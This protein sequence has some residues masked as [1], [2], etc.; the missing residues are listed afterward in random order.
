MADAKSSAA[1]QHKRRWL[2]VLGIVLGVLIVLLVLAYFTVTSSAFVKGVIL[3]RVGKAMNAD[4]TAGEAGVSPFSQIILKNLKVQ[5]TGTEPLLTAN[6]VRLKY[7]LFDILGG[8]IAVDEVTLDTPT[9]NVIANADGTS[10]LDPLTKSSAPKEA[11][12]NAVN[13]ASP[14]PSK[15]LRI[16][17]K[18]LAVT[19]A[20]IRQTQLF[21]DGSR[22]ETDLLNVNVTLN[23][24]K[25]GATG[26][27]Q[28]SAIASLANQ[29]PSP[30][31]LQTRIDG[32]FDFTPDANFKSVTVK[33]G[34]KFDVAQAAGT[35]K[36]FADF[37]GELDCD[38]T[39]SNIGQVALKFHKSGQQLGQLL[40]SGPFDMAKSEG[41]LNVQILSLDRRVLDFFGASSGVDFGGTTINSTN[42]I[43]LT[44][45]GA[46]I[47][48]SGNVTIANLQLIRANQ[49]TPTLDAEMNYDV[50]IDNGSKTAILR[51]V[52]LSATQNGKPLARAALSQPM[53]LSWSGAAQNVGDSTLDLNVTGMNLADWKPFLGENVGGGTFSLESKLLA[54]AGGKQI[55]FSLNSRIANLNASAGNSK[56]EQA[57]L[58]FTA[59]GS[60]AEFKQFKLD[61]F[62]AQ[63]SRQ[64]KPALTISGSGTSEPSAQTADLNIQLQAGLPELTQLLPQPGAN[65][66][67]GTIDATA[68]I[69]Q[70]GAHQTVSGKL[71]VASLTG[72]FGNDSFQNYSVAANFDVAKNEEQLQSAHAAGN[73]A[74]NA[75]PGGNF[76]VSANYDD[77]KNLNVTAKLDGINESG[78]RPFLESALGDKK[79][80]SI[81]LNGN[82]SAQIDA[83]NN[84][85]AKADLQLANLVV[86]DPA[87]KIPATPLAAGFQLDISEKD[88]VADLNQVKI[89]LTPTDKAKNE[90]Q[91]SGTVD[92]TKTN[93][94]IGSLK[95]A[96]DSLDVTR[97]YDLF[98]AN[99][100][101]APA[102]ANAQAQQPAAATAENANQEPDAMKLPFGLF[103]VDAKIGKFYL[104]EVSVSDL[105]ASAKI[106]GSHVTLD[107]C[108]FTMNGSPVN[109]SIDL[110]LG[111]P[112]YEYG[113]V[114]NAKGI[115][116]APLANSFSTDYA[117]RAKG[118]FFA[119]I[120]IK[121]AGV[122]GKNLKKT[123]VGN[124]DIIVTNAIIEIASQK[125]NTGKPASTR[126]ERY[127]TGPAMQLL[128]GI[129]FVLSDTLGLQELQTSPLT[130]ID[131][132]LKMGSGTITATKVFAGSSALQV[133]TEGTI[134]I[135]NVLTNSTINDWPVHL[136]IGRSSANKL[137]W[138]TT[139]NQMFVTLPDFVT[140]NQT[141]G[142]TGY[143]I[144]K[145]A[146]AEILGRTGLG[147]ANKLTGSKGATN[148][149]QE[150]QNLI[151]SK[152][153]NSLFNLLKN[154]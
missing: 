115:P 4:I 43:E 46:A 72:K 41:R 119:D 11:A 34:A 54:H 19:N 10:N 29:S 135:A 78:L 59:S 55:E 133:Q 37:G 105:T 73:L 120:N 67:S 62:R 6:E 148:T 151:N 100:S 35:M 45:A 32:S 134:T 129:I 50:T 31:S 109:M 40:V 79:L 17:V 104:R 13:A 103:T 114:F 144:N 26:K 125:S 30:G 57:Q 118:D 33:G 89:T 12:T 88:K 149:V 126:V 110:N 139:A 9:I 127:F 128:D 51:A 22:N 2:R 90:V 98:T 106:D 130:E 70:K 136:A 52:N 122:T 152:A 23:D 56:I 61:D 101:P 93:A 112:G 137:G 87:G 111:V 138:P 97:Y 99:K 141:I 47:S 140:L 131:T 63:L 77:K 83:K 145:V 75:K 21:K 42:T 36:D 113:I 80:A 71:T 65:F 16:D 7:H 66:S 116:I 48:A 74:G 96:A 24:L 69:S 3:P 49:S 132:H 153:A 85:N 117:G 92:M 108:Q 121:G 64:N 8:N 143:K 39:P 25:N 27:L 18:K 81:T 91:L 84:V 44:K 28:L 20:T 147:V 53:N 124:V 95:L 68:N 146:V 107:P 5:T 142:N 102:A 123:L 14:P 15:P 82:A 94:I 58:S 76:D 38:V 86:N 1:P 150:I 60:V 154:R